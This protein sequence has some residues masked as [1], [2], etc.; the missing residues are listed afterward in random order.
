MT[1]STGVTSMETSE[2]EGAAAPP[3]TLSPPPPPHDE[4]EARKNI[5]NKMADIRFFMFCCLHSVLIMGNHSSCP[6][7]HRIERA[8]RTGRRIVN[9][10]RQLLI[11]PGNRGSFADVPI[12]D[13]AFEF[14]AK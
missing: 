10:I 3:P 9:I 14:E 7:A 2:T 11:T 12:W 5:D 1:G 13:S 4:M 8:V 6:I